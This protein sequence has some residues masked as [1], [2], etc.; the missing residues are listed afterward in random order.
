[1]DV[2]LVDQD[3][4]ERDRQRAEQRDQRRAAEVGLGLPARRT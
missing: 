4:R 2:G 1:M 3:R